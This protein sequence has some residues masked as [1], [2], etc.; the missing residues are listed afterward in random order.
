MPIHYRAIQSHDVHSLVYA[1]VLEIW[2]MKELLDRAYCYFVGVVL[3]LWWFLGYPKIEYLSLF[4][5]FY[6]IVAASKLVLY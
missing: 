5:C 6:Q 3:E 1:C 4:V 2:G